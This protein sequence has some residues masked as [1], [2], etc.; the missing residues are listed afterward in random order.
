MTVRATRQSCSVTSDGATPRPSPASQ[1]TSGTRTKTFLAQS[2]GRRSLR[3]GGTMHHQYRNLRLISFPN[4]PRK[5]ADRLESDRKR[6]CRRQSRAPY[7]PFASAD[8]R[9][10]PSNQTRKHGIGHHHPPC[11]EPQRARGVLHHALVHRLLDGKRPLWTAFTKL[12]D[13]R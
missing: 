4:F 3:V 8:S 12:E 7:L 2:P 5:P 10:P 13:L 1:K 11:R 6:L 9:F